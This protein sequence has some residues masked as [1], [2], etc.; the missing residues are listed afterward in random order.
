MAAV[1]QQ[2]LA[3]YQ[4]LPAHAR[5]PV[6]P[7]VFDVA[8]HRL[9][10]NKPASAQL[11]P[12]E[13]V[14][15]R[16][17]RRAPQI[18]ALARDDWGQSQYRVHIPLAELAKQLR[19]ERAAIWRTRHQA[20][21]ELADIVQLDPD[22]L[23]CLHSVDDG[24]LALLAALR[25]QAKPPRLVFLLDDLLT[26]NTRWTEAS[27]RLKF[28]ATLR[29]AIQLCDVCICTSGALADRMGRELKLAASKFCV[30]PNALAGGVWQAM[31]RHAK[32][33]KTRRLRVLW[34]GGAG[35][36]ADLELLMPVIQA[37]KTQYQWVFFGQR[38]GA[39]AHDRDIEFHSGVAFADYPAKLA[40]LQ[41]DIAVA[42][43][44]QNAFN[45]CKSPL[46]LLEYGA[47]ALPVVAS[48]ITPY[49]TAPVLLAKNTAQWLSALATLSH[50]DARAHYAQRLCDWVKCEYLIE[51]ESN[52]QRWMNA[53][54][55]TDRTC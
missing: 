29:R 46:K 22:A 20:L 45:Q 14:R 28:A 38:P 50:A 32:D 49:L 42:P 23:L 24:A 47:L 11:H 36:D 43:L 55:G 4:S 19:I 12:L 52:Q 44:V 41:A 6:A 3:I 33:D 40:Q 9:Q 1:A 31:N 26:A 48:P 34:A 39:L 27:A 53:I 18:V 15:P 17:Q 8:T 13:F 16:A 35:H 25:S 2:Y 51:T 7:A 37:S 30:V 21:P 54:F 5:S 10:H